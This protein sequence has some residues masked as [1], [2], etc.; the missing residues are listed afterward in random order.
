M[1][2]KNQ[3]VAIRYLQENGEATP[4]ELADALG[5]A[6]KKIHNLLQNMLRYGRLSREGKKYRLAPNELAGKSLHCKIDPR[7][8]DSAEKRCSAGMSP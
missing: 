2:S 5:V 1:N 8:P 3:Q 7:A 6:N 4:R